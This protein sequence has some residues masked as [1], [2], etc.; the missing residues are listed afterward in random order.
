MTKKVYHVRNWKDYNAS[1]VNR[2]NITVW[3]DEDLLKIWRNPGAL[4]RRG[5]PQVYPDLII[6]CGL[7]LRSLFKLPLRATEGLLISLTSLMELGVEVPDYTT[8]SKR[9]K[10]LRIKRIKKIRKEGEKIDIVVDSTGLKVFGEGEWKMRQHGKS[11]RRTWRKIHLAID[12]KEFEIAGALV[13]EARCHDGEAMPILLESV[14]EKIDK[15]LGDGA[16]DHETNYDYLR[17]RGIEAIIPPRENARIKQHG[18]CKAEALSRDEAIRFINKH[19]RANWKKESGYHKRSLAETM[20]YCFKTAFG[21]KLQ[22]R[23]LE[24][25]AT[26][27]GIKCN[28]LNQWRQFGRAES[29]IV[30]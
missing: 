23:L 10:G 16:Y 8:L 11:K 19:G 6:E 13:T 21:D 9:Q 4:G 29:Y 24:T 14:Q 18:N 25:Q 1:L 5:R 28:I 7:T 17:E 2:G 22:N 3:L 12:A 30:Q 27:V 20:M 15:F 26:E